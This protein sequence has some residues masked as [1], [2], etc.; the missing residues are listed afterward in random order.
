MKRS[1]KI[2][3]IAAALS[4]G[5]I[6][7]CGA[8]EQKG[9][10]QVSLYDR[11]LRLVERMDTMAESEN[12]WNMMTSSEEMV[13][14]IKEIGAQDY[15]DPRAVYQVKLSENSTD[16]LIEFLGGESSY[17]ELPEELREEL[18]DRLA[19]SIATRFS[20]MAGTEMLAAASVLASSDHF[21]DSSLTDNLT[22]FYIYDNGYWGAVTFLPYED[23][24]VHASGLMIKSDIFG[25][26]GEE[27]LCQ[28]FTEY[29]GLLEE[30]ISKVSP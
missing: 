4:L 13:S 3:W 24:I 6:S 22:Y 7:G 26:E 12:Y 27:E 5:L 29:G 28:W 18:E 14:V 8:G 20:A 23:G 30:D 21:I 15:S 11:G 2:R 9:K 17:N 25:E 19:S 1:R 16:L 10:E